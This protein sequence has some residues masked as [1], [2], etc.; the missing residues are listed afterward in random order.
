MG[1]VR[2]TPTIFQI[3][4]TEC[5][6]ASLSMILGYYGKHLPLEQL[7]VETGVSRNGCNA[8]NILQA[9]KKFGLSSTAKRLEP[10]ELFQEDPPCIIHWNMDHF[11]VYEGVRNNK[12]YL[13]D[14]AQGRRTVSIEDFNDSF[15]G[16][17]MFFEKTEAFVKSNNEDSV[18]SFF[19][20]RIDHKSDTIVP[21]IVFGIL[22]LVP[23][24]V[25]PKLTQTF[26]N[27]F[28]AGENLD[29]FTNFILLMSI[30]VLMQMIIS[31]YRDIIL[32]RFRTKLTLF[33]G[34]T[35]LEH[36]FRLP[37]SF[38]DQRYSGD[39]S[40]RVDDNI[41][42]SE[43]LSGELTK[44]VLSL[45]EAGIY[46]FL[47]FGMNVQ[48]TWIALASVFIQRMVIRIVMKNFSTKSVKLQQDSGKLFGALSAGLRITPT[49]KASG[50][51]NAY[52]SRILG[53][54]ARKLRLDQDLNLTQ[55]VLNGIPQGLNHITTII[56]LFIAVKAIHQGAFS[57]G[58]YLAFSSYYGSFAKPVD[59]LTKTYKNI[60]TLKAN[61]LRVQDIENYPLDWK[62]K[63]HKVIYMDDKLQGRV[64]FHNI[65]FG[66][67]ILEEA[68]IKD[69]SFDLLPGQSIALVGP[70]GSGK[71]T[72]SKLASG[73]YEPWNGKIYLD[74]IPYQKVP[75][76]I[77][78]SSIATVS[79]DINLFSGTV[80]DNL[81]L[82]KNSVLE[83]D[84]IQA[85][86]DACIH[87]D[88]MAREGG[89]DFVLTEEGQNFSG[90]Q[91]Q[92]LEIARALSIN[93]SIIILDE[94]TSALDPITEKKI[95]DNIKR[96]GCTCIVVAHRLSAVRDS[97]LILAFDNGRVVQ[98][99]NHRELMKQP[100]IYRTLV[101]RA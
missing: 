27:V 39:I 50:A 77:L 15:T 61:I 34:R 44:I 2:K 95:M 42:V 20:G 43:F 31:Y 4:A 18:W 17:A 94:A 25:L 1:K 71:S 66:Y 21:L 67:G 55:E 10:E 76:D 57:V 7:R 59:E 8:W 47:L 65:S 88:I 29:Y 41:A 97:D 22:L 92:R 48:L 85:A 30:F 5:G 19:R 64:T 56:M 58:A 96:R 24:I 70:S 75:A 89:Y 3:E 73:L 63:K 23:G 68:L 26:V 40:R 83:S 101:D 32:M 13:N 51:E 82:W 46:L 16:I 36:L 98:S 9:A 90:G 74:R 38:F 91:R 99:G 80:R 54:E 93:P 6:A 12:V 11:L 87:D 14:P 78:N 72:V 52:I 79:Q 37:I 35:F 81:T 84:M 49:L 60:K 45:F 53:F 28:L 86:K 33:S 69:L 100:G 62:F